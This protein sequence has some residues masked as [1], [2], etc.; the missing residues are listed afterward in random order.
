M[1]R[2]R[3]DVSTLSSPELF[4]QFRSDYNAAKAS[5]YRR[6]PAGVSAVGSS[7]DYHYRTES[8]YLRMMELARHFFRNNPVIAQ[9]VRRLVTNCIQDGFA[10]DPQTG[11]DKADK[12]LA[13]RW[14][15]W[16]RQCDLCDVAGRLSFHQ[17]EQ[18]VLQSTIVDGDVLV[19][20]QRT[21][22]LQLVEA[23]RL[24]S[25]TNARCRR[26][27]GTQLVHGVL[28]DRLRR[29]LEYWLTADDINPS[30]R[31]RRVNEMRRYAA[32]DAEGRRQV[33]HIY[34]PDRISQ[35]RGITAFAPSV[36]TIGMGD[37]LFFA[38]LVKAQHGSVYSI[39]HEFPEL[40]DGAAPPQ[41]GEQETETLSDG[42]TRTIEG[43]APGM[44]IF[45]RPGEKLTGFTP[46][47]PNPEFFAH[48]K[49][50]LTMISI[51]LDLPLAVFLLDPSETNFSGWRGAIDQARLGFR[52]IQRWLCG[53]FHE[54]V[55]QF[56][57]RQWIAAD[58]VLEA[59]GRQEGVN[60]F[61]HRWHPP[62]WKYIEPLK[63]A[64]ADLLRCRN[65]LI[66]HRRRCNER[67]LDWNDLSTEI[68]DDNA[69]LIRKA[70]QKADELN[71]EFPDLSVTWREVASLPTP[72]GVKIGIEA[73]SEEKTADGK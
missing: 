51:N 70:K 65:A 66:S 19:L 50:I 27:A 40:Y 17:Q 10:L 42:S 6:T 35:T 71:K 29:P 63:D 5:R 14:A 2:C 32:R 45:G 13:G 59:I 11:N 12:I 52:R 64:S 58:A 49:L 48:A 38:M 62:E 53:A 72:D 56:K 37:D 20:P 47:I 68:V 57:V 16:S 3:R 21:G 43:V 33:F 9:A 54:P 36:D 67:G 26:A 23:H 8:D 55:Y 22:Q 69:M 18:L 30:R 31:V 73:H 44:E 24:R 25:P 28:L 46:N 60:L 7:A 41:K 15:E 34:W 39:F 1:S 61:A 4:E